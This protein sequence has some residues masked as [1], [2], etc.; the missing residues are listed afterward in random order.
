MENSGL[1][2]GWESDERKEMLA[3]SAVFAELGL[4][5][6]EFSVRW[7]RDEQD[8]SGEPVIWMKVTQ[9]STGQS[10]SG[11]LGAGQREAGPIQL[12]LL[13]LLLKSLPED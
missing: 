12:E 11:K 8:S 10:V 1:G 6:Q 4:S 3:Q 13:R 5:P 2:Q 7:G 9:L